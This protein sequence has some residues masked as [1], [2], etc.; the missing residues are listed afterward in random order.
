MTVTGQPAGS[1]TNHSIRATLGKVLGLFNQEIKRE[2]AILFAWMLFGAVLEM[3]GTALLVLFLDVVAKPAGI[4][5]R[6]GQLYQILAGGDPKRFI[7]VFGVT[8]AVL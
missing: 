7:L 6:F 4:G 3:I 8:I 5:D 2:V 1:M